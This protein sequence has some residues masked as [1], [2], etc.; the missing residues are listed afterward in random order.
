M[1]NYMSQAEA[2][3]Y[4]AGKSPKKY[5]VTLELG[6]QSKPDQELKFVSASTTAGAI[7]TARANAFRVKNPTRILCRLATAQD[8]GCVR[9][10]R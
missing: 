10:S 6:R 1:S 9:T 7:K 2:N 4:W 5:V 8:L 3:A